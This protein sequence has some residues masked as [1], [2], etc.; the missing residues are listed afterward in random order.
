MTSW[1]CWRWCISQ[2]LLKPR[3]RPHGALGSFTS[4]FDS[5]RVIYP[6]TISEQKV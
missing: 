4:T 6:P 2:G 3:V 1:G 5:R